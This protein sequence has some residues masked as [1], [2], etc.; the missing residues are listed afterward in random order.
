MRAGPC[1]K[2]SG[3]D[4]AEFSAPSARI[5]VGHPTP[6]CHTRTLGLFVSLDRYL[7]PIAAT[8]EPSTSPSLGPIFTSGISLLRHNDRRISIRH[9]LRD[10]NRRQKKNKQPVIP[11]LIWCCLHM[12]SSSKLFFKYFYRDVKRGYDK[13]R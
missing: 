12:T 8:A 9:F 6:A 4:S 10:F 13:S 3:R 2:V 1:S 5:F 11:S 7:R